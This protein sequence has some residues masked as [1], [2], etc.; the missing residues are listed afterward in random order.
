M[1]KE[2]ILA[3]AQA[4]RVDER[5]IFINDRSIRWTYLVMVMAAGIFMIV[6]STRDMPIT[7]LCA[8][9]C[10][11]VAA[12]NIYRGIKTKDKWYF[13]AGIVVAASGIFT[14]VR[15]FMGY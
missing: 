2:E 3:K 7:D 6:R 10:L 11:A 5:E 1:K 12:G 14:A 9:V 8:T 13:I 4:E 15:F